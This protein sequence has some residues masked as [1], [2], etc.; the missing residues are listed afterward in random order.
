[1]A[2]SLAET[3]K[4]DSQ[5]RTG[6]NTVIS[7]LPPGFPAEVFTKTQHV[8]APQ[9]VWEIII[10]QIFLTFVV[11]VK[12]LRRRSSA[13]QFVMASMNNELEISRSGRAII[14]SITSLNSEQSRQMADGENLFEE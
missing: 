8:S 7:I 2:N 13:L 11:Q 14:C 4:Y 1:M 6:K 10:G 9:L 3:T 12:I 5:G